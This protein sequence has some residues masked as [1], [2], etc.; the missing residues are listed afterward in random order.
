MS[1][2]FW[3]NTR[4][5][6]LQVVQMKS[7]QEQYQGLTPCL[8]PARCFMSVSLSAFGIQALPPLEGMLKSPCAQ[9]GKLRCRKRKANPS[10]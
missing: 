4:V 7:R 10:T 5:T 3:F 2:R 1:L 8:T 9:E 6:T